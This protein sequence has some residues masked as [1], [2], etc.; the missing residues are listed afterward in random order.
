M[1]E[2]VLEAIAARPLVFDGA[3]GTLLYD[4]G[5]F[6]NQVFEELCV[7][8]PSKVRNVHLEYIDAGADI[9]ETNTF[10]ANRI[11]LRRHG[12]EDQVSEINTAA[13][14][15]AIQAARGRAYVAGAIGP[16]SRVPSVSSDRELTEIKEAFEEQA[17]VLAGGGVDLIVIETFRLL[18]EMRIALAAVKAT[19]SLPVVAQMAFDEDAQTGDGA[20]PERVAD[21]LQEWG[22]DVVG[23]NCMEGPQVSFEVA[24]RM[25]GRGAPVSVQPNAG[26]P[27]KV[28]ERLLY[29][30]TPEYFAEYAR[31]CLKKGVSLYGGCCGT[32]PLHIRSALGAARMMSGGRVSISAAPRK[33]ADV[34]VKSAPPLSLAKKSA[35]GA[36]LDRVQRERVLAAKP[37]ALGPE[38]FAVSVEINSPSGLDMRR[39]LDAAAVVKRAGCD[40]VNI[41][42]GPRATV[43]VSNGVLAAVIQDQV[44]IETLVH[45]CARDRNLLRLQSD[46]LGAHVSGV[47]NLVMITGD[48]PKMG[49]YPNATAVYDVDAI[50]LL[51]L[52]SNLN[53]GVDPSGRAIG[54]GTEFVM[55]CGAEP[56]AIDYDREIRRLEEKARAGAEFIM[57][58]P[59]YGED[60]LTRFLDDT[61]HLHLP[62]LV[63][64]LPLASYKNA[65][66][67]HHEVPGMTIPTTVLERMER[68]GRGPLARAEGVQ[69]AREALGRFKDRVAGVYIMP[70]FNNV[71][72]AIEVLEEVGF[73][74]PPSA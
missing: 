51:K 23:C 28:D 64:I 61:K 21:L 30:V 29:M 13:A 1:N 14:E 38:S 12:L 42:D 60:V 73:A 57:T 65:L 15:I 48:P 2:T 58:Q 10:G 55:A 40:V 32:T 35:L 68:V 41:A 72:S 16:T 45:F 47:R 19:T 36:K 22:A 3:M 7:S 50:G 43:R 70:P 63:G 39:A 27:R 20:A 24:S 56:A 11:R 44:G 71:M 46:L 5:V 66:F 31:R 26:Y 6:I 54:K 69:I 52:A 17:I 37:V 25:V 9:I 59:V 74:L 18:S 8:Q 62:V 49:D 67:L 33:G 34:V 53:R 4:R